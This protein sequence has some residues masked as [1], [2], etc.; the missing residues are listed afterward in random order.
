MI[1]PLSILLVI[2]QVGGMIANGSIEQTDLFGMLD[3]FS[4]ST[5]YLV[6]HGLGRKALSPHERRH[7]PVLWPYIPLYWFG[8]SLAAWR[9]FWQLLHDP[10]G[11]EKTPHSPARHSINGF[12]TTPKKPSGS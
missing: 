5:A 7:M 9:A 11:W 1:H 6:F 4:I 3:L 8:L 10:H 12:S 2:F